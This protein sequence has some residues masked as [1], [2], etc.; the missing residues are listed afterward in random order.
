M[1][2]TEYSRGLLAGVLIG[3][4]IAMIIHAVFGTL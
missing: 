4:I 2:Q 1:P 3:T